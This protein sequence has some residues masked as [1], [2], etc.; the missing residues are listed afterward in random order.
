[1]S[2]RGHETQA[3]RPKTL[4]WGPRAGPVPFLLH[5]ASTAEAQGPPGSSASC[6]PSLPQPSST[7]PSLSRQLTFVLK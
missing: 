4:A 2:K 3:V 6:D 7:A 1:V 5:H